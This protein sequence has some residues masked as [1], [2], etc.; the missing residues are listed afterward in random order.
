MEV[1]SDHVHI[2]LSA[3]PRY[4]LA[5]VVNILKGVSSRTM[6]NDF[7]ELKRHLWGGELWSDGHFVRTVGD[8]VTTDVI[9]KIHSLTITSMR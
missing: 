5:E 9:K 8:R 2:F 4:S 3:P 7:P 6:F 1:I